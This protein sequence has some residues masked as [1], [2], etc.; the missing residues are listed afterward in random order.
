MAGMYDAMTADLEKDNAEEAESQKGFEALM[1]TKKEERE[2]LEAIR[3]KYSNPTPLPPS[4][5]VE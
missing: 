4:I 2:T 5:S 3:G 1:A